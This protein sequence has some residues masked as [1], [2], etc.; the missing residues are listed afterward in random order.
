M[1]YN[2]ALYG[3]SPS[4][5]LCS[6]VRLAVRVALCPGTL[7]LGSTLEFEECVSSRAALSLFIKFMFNLVTALQNRLQDRAQNLRDA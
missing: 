6:V 5:R 3:D 2:A 4:P 7:S 1:E